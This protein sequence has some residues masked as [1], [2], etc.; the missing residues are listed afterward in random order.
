MTRKSAAAKMKP[1]KEALVMYGTRHQLPLMART[2]EKMRAVFFHW[3]M[4]PI[5]Y[6]LF[7]D[8]PEV[9]GA[10][11]AFAQYWNDEANDA[12]HYDVIP[13]VSTELSWAEAFSAK[14]AP[15]YDA[16]EETVDAYNLINEAREK[17]HRI[18]YGSH[19]DNDEL[20]TAFA[21]VVGE[22]GSQE[23]STRESYTPYVLAWPAWV[24]KGTYDH[25]TKTRGTVDVLEVHYE[26]VGSIQRP[27]LEDQPSAWRAEAAG[28]CHNC[29]RPAHEH[30]DEKCLFMPTTYVGLD[31]FD[32]RIF[33]GE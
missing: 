9:K 24:S 12:V 8:N 11:I 14:N 21:S 20:I 17:A 26:I 27:H 7:N 28:K 3:Y 31:P 13:L 19:W 1:K 30:K 2:S 23:D 33:D 29:K 10:Y 15:L 18:P 5:L 22:E 4:G 16:G 6:Q 25:K 32:D